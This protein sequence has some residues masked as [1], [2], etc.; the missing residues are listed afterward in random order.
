M[1]AP[2]P[3]AATRTPAAAISRAVLRRGSSGSPMA[4]ARVSTALMRQ[5]GDQDQAGAEHEQAPAPLVDRP[6]ARR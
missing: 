3:K 6:A 1:T 4:R 2:E 5:L